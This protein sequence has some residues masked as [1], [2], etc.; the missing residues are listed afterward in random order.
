MNQATR[1]KKE[2]TKSLFELMK[3]KD[4]TRIT[5]TEIAQQALLD[6][7]T[8]YRHY[9]QKEEIIEDYCDELCLA[10]I[11]RLKQ[12]MPINFYLMAFIYFE[13]WYEHREFLAL[14]ISSH[15]YH[16]VIARY[17]TYLPHI[18]EIFEGQTFEYEN[19]TMEKYALS[20]SIGGFWHLLK[21][22]Q[23]NGMQETP[24]EMATIMMKAYVLVDKT[25]K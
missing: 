10:Y 23:K 16:F 6:R 14:I 18:R 11:G 21:V 9:V 24:E 8:F 13:F 5:V 3:R 2:L 12:V 15:L 20:F 25:K 22:W 19:T 17:D 1:S 4:F 7:R